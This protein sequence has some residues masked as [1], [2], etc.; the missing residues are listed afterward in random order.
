MPFDIITGFGIGVELRIGDALGK[1]VRLGAGMEIFVGMEVSVA[2]AAVFTITGGA[3]GIGVAG[4]QAKIDKP[5]RMVNMIREEILFIFYLP[6]IFSPP[7]A[8]HL[9]DKRPCLSTAMM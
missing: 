7:T 3:G 8:V 5:I 1:S 9:S 6:S 4:L 2:E